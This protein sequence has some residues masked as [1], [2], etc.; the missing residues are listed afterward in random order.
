MQDEA[1][2]ERF[3]ERAA[4][5]RGLVPPC[6]QH[7]GMECAAKTRC[8]RTGRKALD[9]PCRRVLRDAGEWPKS[10]NEEA[11]RSHGGRWKVICARDKVKPS[12]PCK[13]AHPQAKAYLP[14]NRRMT[15]P[16]CPNW[17]SRR[18]RSSC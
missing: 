2:L 12:A 4:K 11:E 3:K 5:R 14:W 8:R 1:G 6:G 15:R 9:E 7:L 13:I 18:S 17:G 16:L 10:G